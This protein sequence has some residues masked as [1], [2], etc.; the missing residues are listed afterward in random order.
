MRTKIFCKINMKFKKIEWKDNIILN[1]F[2]A[3][4]SKVIK[5]GSRHEDINTM[6]MFV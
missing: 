4:Y 6:K 3:E 2:G 5:S 1:S